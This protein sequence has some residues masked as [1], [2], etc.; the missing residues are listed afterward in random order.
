MEANSKA[1]RNGFK[2]P[3]RITLAARAMKNRIVPIY[4]L[5]TPI[6]QTEWGSVPTDLRY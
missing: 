2:A 5:G 3:V 1:D 4:N 6:R